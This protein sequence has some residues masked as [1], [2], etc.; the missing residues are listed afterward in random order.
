MAILDEAKQHGLKV[1]EPHAPPVDCLRYPVLRSVLL[2]RT[3]L[4][5]ELRWRTGFLRTGRLPR[6]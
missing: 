3:P 6:Q 1:S 2:R 4:V 5:G